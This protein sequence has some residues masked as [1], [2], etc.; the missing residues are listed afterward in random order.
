M[1]TSDN[2]LFREV[3][4]QEM[5]AEFKKQSN[6]LAQLSCEATEAL[7]DASGAGLHN[8][9][10]RGK[11]LGS[12]L[13]AAQSAEIRAGT[14]KD[15]F[16]GDFWPMTVTYQYKDAND[17]TQTAT[18]TVNFRIADCDYYL[19]S[20]DTECTA[21]HL[22]VVP[23]VNL[24]T[25]RMN[26]ENKTEGAY[27]GSEMYTKNLERAKALITA[28]FGAGHILTHRVVLENAVTDGKPSGGGWFNST[29]E[30]M[31]EAMVYGCRHFGS[32]VQDGGATVY[33]R[34]TVDKTQLNLF[35]HRPDLISNRQWYWL[36]DVVNGACFAHVS[37]N[38][39]PDC[40]SAS[41]SGGGVRPDF[42]IY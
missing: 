42:L 40:T 37:S 29:V 4:A 12:V 3:T 34:Y 24:Y 18:I 13:T 38:G 1:A 33:Y 22:V 14:F 32:G 9:F 23:D 21:H 6:Y 39:C 7:K 19:R 5:L 17:V 30:L 15:L 36:R 20:G 11:N 35:R 10:F 16:V 31:T 27:V 2:K 41:N 28:A 25:A 26:A 8:S